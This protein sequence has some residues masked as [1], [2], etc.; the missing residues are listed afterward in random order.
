[1]VTLMGQSCRAL[2]AQALLVYFNCVQRCQG[3]VTAMAVGC[4]PMANL[5]FGRIHG[6]PPREQ[7]PRTSH[8]RADPGPCIIE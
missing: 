1:M 6:S 4:G 8:L 5:K 7:Q 2:V 3:I